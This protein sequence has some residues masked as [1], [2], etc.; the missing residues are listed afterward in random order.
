MFQWIRWTCCAWGCGLL[1][2]VPVWA[3][4]AADW[5]CEVVY[6]PARAVWSRSV[7]IGYDRRR[8]TD[9]RIDGVPVY[10]FMVN[11]TKVST[12]L[13]NERIQI[14]AGRRSWRSD[15]RG[16]AQ[17]EGRC[18]LADTKGYDGAVPGGVASQSPR[19]R[20]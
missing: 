8:I 1:A 7:H 13:D 2:S 3:A 6:Q 16:Q 15:F 20:P 17:G 14:D 11:G 10:A 9:V 18:E 12:A 4:Q 5:R 19:Q